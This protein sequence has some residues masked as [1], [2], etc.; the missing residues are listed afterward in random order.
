M[1]QNITDRI[2]SEYDEMRSRAVVLRDKR[3][4]KYHG[5][6][7]E[8]KEIKD[9][10]TAAGIEH[11]MKM[12]NNPDD[13]DKIRLSLESVLDELNKRK[14]QIIAENDIPED[15][16][17]IRYNC[18][19]CGDTGFVE[20]EKC[21]CYK[22]KLTDYAYE[23]SNLSVYMKAASFEK[24]DFSYFSDEPEK[25]GISPLDR[26]KKAYNE[27]VKMC[28]SFD[29]YRKSFLYFGDTGLGKTYLSSCIANTLI[30]K[31]YSVLYI[32]SNRLFDV[33]ENKKFNRIRSEEEAETATMIYDC[34][35]LIIDDLGTEVINKMTPA[36]LHDI[37]NERIMADKKMIIS[38]N[39]SPDELSKNYTPRLV[40]RL[41]E[42]FYALKFIGMDIRKQKMYE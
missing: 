32:T 13:E 37:V 11:A 28:N 25:D 21:R 40:S 39:L 24:F 18:N 34:D 38:T 22:A 35:L 10:I 8:L 16:D 17:K 27:A 31:G 1:G 19:L 2:F 7:P 33:M 12:A 23:R 6:F 42:Y 15:Y 26:I 41:F 3:I 14:R 36:F 29:E 9:E 20:N 5:K 4:E 30:E